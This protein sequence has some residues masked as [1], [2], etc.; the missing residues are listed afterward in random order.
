MS[1]GH[2]A[3]AG[4]RVP[5]GPRERQVKLLVRLIGQRFGYYVSPKSKRTFGQGLAR[6]FQKMES[7]LAQ[8]YQ[9]IVEAEKAAD[10]QN[11]QL[12]DQVQR[13]TDTNAQ[14]S[15]ALEQ[16]TAPPAGGDAPAPPAAGDGGGGGTG[17]TPE[18]PAPAAGEHD[19]GFIFTTKGRKVGTPADRQALDTI[20]DR[21]TPDAPADPEFQPA[22]AAPQPPA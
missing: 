9:A 18:A 13:L 12:R 15:Q 20:I 3:D 6:E 5:S 21:A 2:D 8:A 10:A 19:G 11:E 7:L 4:R 16:A 1:R 17:T 14:L 22:P